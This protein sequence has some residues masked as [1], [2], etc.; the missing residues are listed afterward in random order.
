MNDR[1]RICAFVVLVLALGAFTM[2]LGASPRPH[3]FGTKPQ[4]HPSA[5]PTQTTTATP[6]STATPTLTPTPE[7]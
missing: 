4:Q 3:P 6:E 5:T 7:G 2:S 1:S